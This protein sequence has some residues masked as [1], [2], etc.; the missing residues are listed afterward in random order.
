MVNSLTVGELREMIED[1]QDDDLVL[2]IDQTSEGARD[3]CCEVY[4]E[5]SLSINISVVE[6][7]AGSGYVEQGVAESNV[8]HKALIIK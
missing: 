6:N 2:V 3:D 7:D 4:T 5:A 8:I 1:M